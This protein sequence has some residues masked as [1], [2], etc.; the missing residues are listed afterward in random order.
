MAGKARRDD[1]EVQAKVLTTVLVA[2]KRGLTEAELDQRIEGLDAL[3]IEHAV[4]VL[5]ASGLLERIEARLHPSGAAT[6]FSRR[7]PL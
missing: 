1:L 5:L 2:G 6:H 7:T 3:K 4:E